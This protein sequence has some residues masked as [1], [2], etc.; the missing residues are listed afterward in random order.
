MSK[1]SKKA[2]KRRKLNQPEPTTRKPRRRTE[3]HPREISRRIARGE[4]A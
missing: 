3:N 2:E 1:E 4:R